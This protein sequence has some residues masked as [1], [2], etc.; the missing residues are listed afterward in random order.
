MSSFGLLIAEDEVAI[1]GTIHAFARM[2]GSELGEKVNAVLTE[3]ASPNWFRTLTQA[4]KEAAQ[5]V[6]ED[7]R[8]PRFLLK[9]S[10]DDEGIIHLA[11][12]NFDSDWK[13]AASALRRKLNSWSHG[14]LDAN[15]DTFL[16]ITQGLL[17]LSE[18][19]GLS[20]AENLKVSVNRARAIQAGLFVPE[21]AKPEIQLTIQDE[22][23]VANL[24]SKRAEISK[25]PPVGSEWQGEKGTRKI[26]ISKQL[27][28]VTEDG[29]SIKDQ[30]GTD[31]DA[32]IE[33]WLRYYPIGGEAKVAQDGAV[34]GFRKGQAYLIGWLGDPAPTRSTNSLMGFALPY[35]YL[36][37][38]NDVRDL[39]SGRLLS[40]EATENTSELVQEL[41]KHLKDG[42]FLSA[43]AYGE[44][45][46]E[47]EGFDPQILT[48]VHKNIWF[49]GHLPG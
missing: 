10:L 44:L 8:D 30:L 11:I 25:R 13:V 1:A 14:S 28:D 21:D 40:I 47:T 31:P 20:I 27:H 5:V 45:F 4:R 34:M 35:E 12:P 43:T 16:Q 32:V 22:Q 6:Y 26:I 2:F 7:F 48:T 33:S 37:I 49:K 24:K 17:F 36:F 42:D 29:V 18:R 15:L 41:G 46:V 39:T 9:E 19:S 3:R 23:F 38:Q